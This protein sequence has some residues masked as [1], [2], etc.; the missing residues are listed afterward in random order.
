MSGSTNCYNQSE[1]RCS[2]T[3][4]ADTTTENATPNV[5]NVL[6]GTADLVG[7][8][9]SQLQE[10]LGFLRL[11]D[12]IQR[13]IVEFRDGPVAIALPQGGCC[14][15]TSLVLDEKPDILPL[16]QELITD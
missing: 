5:S 7:F 2:Y 12:Q 3:S 4:S 6:L 1:R 15:R 9:G 10:V 8:T 11:A 13:L 14:S 16:V